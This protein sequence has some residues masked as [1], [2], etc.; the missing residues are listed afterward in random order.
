MK[1]SE[2]LSNAL[3]PIAVARYNH[4]TGTNK[5]LLGWLTVVVAQPVCYV[6]GCIMEI[7]YGYR[8]IEHA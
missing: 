3:L 2:R 1:K 4:I 5:N 8:F 7:L 6:I